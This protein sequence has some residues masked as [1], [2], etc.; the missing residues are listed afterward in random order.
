MPKVFHGSS[1]NDD[2]N[3]FCR[4]SGIS[5]TFEISCLHPA[6]S[7]EEGREHGINTAFDGHQ[8][9]F[10][11]FLQAGSTRKPKKAVAK[12]CHCPFR[13]TSAYDNNALRLLD[14]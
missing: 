10:N 13:R 8:N 7:S 14:Q 2:I 4:H 11:Q 12:Q 6:T 5:Y 3:A 9:G 1:K